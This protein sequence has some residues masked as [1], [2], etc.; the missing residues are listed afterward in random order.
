M[1]VTEEFLVKYVSRN[2]KRIELFASAYRKLLKPDPDENLSFYLEIISN[3]TSIPV[4][5]ADE[6]RH[7]Q[8][9]ANLPAHQQNADSLTDELL[10][11]YTIYEPI[12]IEL[13]TQKDCGFT[14]KSH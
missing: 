10:A 2:A 6:N 7:I 3:N 11:E 9:N 14:I 5:I 12:P 8:L 13:G 1:R 4:I